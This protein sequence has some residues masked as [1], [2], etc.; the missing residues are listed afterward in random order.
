MKPAINSTVRLDARESGLMIRALR[1]E[2]I[3]WPRGAWRG[4]T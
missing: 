4:L 2:T 3:G 1:P